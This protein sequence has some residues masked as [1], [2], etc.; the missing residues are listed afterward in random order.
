MLIT[1]PGLYPDIPEAEYHADPVAPGPSLSSSI[2][3]LIV[4]RSP[5]HAWYE[6]PRLNTAKAGEVEKPS[7]QMNIGTAAHKLILG[8]GRDIVEIE[9]A[10]FKTKAAQQARDAALAA[11]KVPVLVDDMP[12]VRT[13]AEAARDGIAGTDLADAFDE[14]VAELTA[15]CRDQFGNWRRI[16]VDWLPAASMKGGHILAVDVK[17]TG[18]SGAPEDWQRTAFDMGYDIQAAFYSQVLSAVLPDVRSVDFR[19][20]TIEQ[21]APYGVSI[22]EFS[23]QA[24]FEAEEL[25]ELGSRMWAECLRRGEWPGY[26]RETTHMD[27][28]KWRSERAEI[29]KLAMFRRIEAWQAPL[30]AN[31]TP[32]VLDKSTLAAE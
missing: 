6:H 3:K 8:K 9:A 23:G 24:R 13:L 1:E 2:C 25:V 30:D 4:G 31:P 17:T 32:L 22:N 10:D 7:R 26:P 27:P 14:G 11:G 21:N 16:R 5:R 29:R 28:P 12:S 20:L 18:G 19:F 15:V